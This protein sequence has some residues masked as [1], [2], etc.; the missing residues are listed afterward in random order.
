MK[1]LLSICIPTDGNVNWVIPVLDSIYRQK[2]DFNL[3]EVV[4]ADNGSNTFLEKALNNYSYENL[5]YKRTT[6]K[7]FLNLITALLIGKGK[8]R[9]MLNHRSILRLG[10]IEEW[11]SLIRQ[12]EKEHPVIYFSDG[13]LLKNKI[14]ECDDFNSFVSTLSY[15]SSWSAGLAIWDCDIDNL[16]DREYNE[17]FP[18]T[19]LL[20]S[21]RNRNR[22]LVVDTKYQDMQ[23]DLGKGGYDLFYT[24]SVEY[25]NVLND[26]RISGDI[27]DETFID[28]K[29]R[30]IGF[31]SYWYFVTVIK[32]SKKYTFKNVDIKKS[33]QIYYSLW[34]YYN[35]CLRAWFIVYT[36]SV[37]K[38]IGS[39]LFEMHRASDR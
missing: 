11:L 34:D 14:I 24:F 2:V 10:I 13:V 27:S 31:F 15:Y 1:P 32:R 29:L 12:Y 3:F 22:Y 5:I 16:I 37:L 30:L 7:G 8:L 19:T 36:K 9:K 17:M 28:I 4:I 6:E 33:F 20:F 38:N 25:L 23:D 21:F 26:L 39:I 18:N 35:V